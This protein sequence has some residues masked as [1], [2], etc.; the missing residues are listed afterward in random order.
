MIMKR[1]ILTT[2][3][4]GTL[5]LTLSSFSSAKVSDFNSLINENISAQQELHGEIKK[6]MNT[7]TQALQGSTN[8]SQAQAAV[9]VDDSVEQV[10]PTTSSKMLRYKKEKSAQSISRKKQM[11]R[12]SQEFNEAESAY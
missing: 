8:G 4:M 11:D 5:A 10:N 6:Q 7:T 1:L 12:I 3:G 9:F 2:L